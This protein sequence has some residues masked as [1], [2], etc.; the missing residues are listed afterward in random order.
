MARKLKDDHDPGAEGTRTE[1]DP[2]AR[3]KVI[4]GCAE[5]MRRI[6]ATRAELNEAAGDIRQKL[7]DCGIDVKS[8]MA[9]LRIVDMDEDAARDT[10]LDGFREAYEALAGGGQMDWIDAVKAGGKGD[11]DDDDTDL[12]PSFMKHN[13]AS[14]AEA[15]AAE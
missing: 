3:A 13:E 1:T 15:V 2:A 7:K 5:E 11:G 10:Y 8:W 4:Q 6:Q 12:R 9:A 14:K